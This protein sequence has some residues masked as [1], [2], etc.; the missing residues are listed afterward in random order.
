M[1]IVLFGDEE[2]LMVIMNALPDLIPQAVIYS[3]RR[4]AAKLK[5]QEWQQA[6]NCQ[7]IVQPLP[8][9]DEEYREFEKMITFLNPDIGLCCFYDLILLPNLL[10]A[11][12]KGVFNIH[13]SLLPK[14]RGANVL[15]WV[16]VNGERETGV[17]LHK[18]VEKVDAGPIVM[19]KRIYIDFLDT[20]ITLRGKLSLLAIEV[21]K[22][23]WIFLKMDSVPCKPQDENKAS[24][25]RRR[26]PEDGFFD[27]NWPAEDIYNLIRA[28]VKPWPGAWYLEGNQKVVIDYF[29]S[30][31][32]VKRMQ[33]EKTGGV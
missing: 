5:A 9:A 21:L 2:G 23:A 27:W 14:Y 18:M 25:Y 17:T 22:E 10:A 30:L 11:F 32:E 33:K 4:P 7:V 15:N 1:N 12:K 16:L 6:T 26:K 29:L 31:E 20:A 24:I 3:C 28:L 8:A 13:T 19:Q